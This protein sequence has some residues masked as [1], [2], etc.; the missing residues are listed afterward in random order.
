MS[1]DKELMF[2]DRYIFITCKLK[3]I[4]AESKLFWDGC[5]L[6]HTNFTNKVRMCKGSVLFQYPDSFPT[7][8]QHKAFG[9]NFR[10]IGF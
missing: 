7:I 3:F 8:D 5:N 1:R 9:S 2:G 4:W 6:C 10:L